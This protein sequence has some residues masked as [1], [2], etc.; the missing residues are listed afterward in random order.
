[1]VGIGDDDVD[2]VRYSDPESIILLGTND[3]FLRRCEIICSSARQSSSKPDPKDLLASTTQLKIPSKHPPR[4]NRRIEVHIY[5]PLTY[6]RRPL[7]EGWP[8]AERIAPTAWHCCCWAS[9]R[10]LYLPFFPKGDKALNRGVDGEASSFTASLAVCKMID[11][12]VLFQNL[13][14]NMRLAIPRQSFRMASSRGKPD[15]VSL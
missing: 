7:R 12:G 11:S 10:F 9:L 15:L 14:S 4:E 5:L 13:E 3:N 8:K 1:M 2:V 6:P